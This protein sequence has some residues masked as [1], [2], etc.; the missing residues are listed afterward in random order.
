[1]PPK[2]A[3]AQRNR[4]KILAAARHAFAE[5]G[6]MP[7]M[8][9]I[10]RR[11]GVGMATLYRNFPGAG[12]A[13]SAVRRRGR[14]AVRRRRPGRPGAPPAWLHLRRVLGEQARRRLRTAQGHSGTDP[15]SAKAETRSPPVPAARAARRPGPRRPHARAGLRHGRGHRH[16]PRA[17]DYTE[18]IPQTALDGL[19]PRTGGEATV[20]T[21]YAGEPERD[22]EPEPA[23]LRE[24]LP[25]AAE[26]GER[27][28]PRASPC[29]VPRRVRERVER[30]VEPPPPDRAQ[31]PR[32]RTSRPRS[33]SVKPMCRP[34]MPAD[35]RHGRCENRAD[36]VQIRCEQRLVS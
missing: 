33:R 14:G 31:R 34:C 15:S 36:R 17:P 3:D 1:M 2:R 32:L 26:Q 11:A 27:G 13:R 18:P 30:A 28:R 12:A 9:E 25:R 6:V 35:P 4:E 7:S 29:R 21:A 16:D 10:S 20:R 8:A 23:Q 24:T 5:P 19:R 22:R